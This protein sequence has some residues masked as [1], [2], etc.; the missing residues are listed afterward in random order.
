MTIPDD[1]AAYGPS[2]ELQAAREALSEAHG[3]ADYPPALRELLNRLEWFLAVPADAKEELRSR[4]CP[5]CRRITLKIR[6]PRKH[7]GARLVCGHPGCDGYLEVPKSRRPMPR[8]ERVCHTQAP[9]NQTGI[10]G[11]IQP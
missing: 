2:L 3:R 4:Q 9:L 7:G 11:K 10:S 6:T 5:K 1:I 8:K